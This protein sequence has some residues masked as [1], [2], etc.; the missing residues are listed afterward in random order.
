MHARACLACLCRWVGVALCFRWGGPHSTDRSP[1]T[2]HSPYPSAPTSPLPLHSTVTP[3]QLFWKLYELQLPS[4]IAEMQAWER[5]RPVYESQQAVRS[6]VDTELARVEALKSELQQAQEK[7]QAVQGE[8]TKK[9]KS[10]RQEHELTV[11]GLR[12]QQAAAA[13]E[14]VRLRGLAQAAGVAL[15]EQAVTAADS[16]AASSPEKPA[17]E[18]EGAADSAAAANEANKFGAARLRTGISATEAEAA[19]MKAAGCGP[20]GAGSAEGSAPDQKKIA[21]AQELEKLSSTVDSY[22]NAVEKAWADVQTLEDKRQ[23]VHMRHM[24][25]CILDTVRVHMIYVCI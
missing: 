2:P 1:P 6:K 3:L 17:D 18:G 11:K 15:P 14:L 24:H 8:Q 16:K 23:Q 4:A 20:S 10:R 9:L 22:Q 25:V 5:V 21:E 12:Q 7:K 19:A 13:K